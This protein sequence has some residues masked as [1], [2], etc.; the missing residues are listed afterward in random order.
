MESTSLQKLQFLEDYSLI[1]LGFMRGMAELNGIVGASYH[2]NTQTARNSQ[3]R[4][5]LLALL[6]NQSKQTWFGPKRFYPES[7]GIHWT[8]GVPDKGK[9][10]KAKAKGV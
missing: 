6:R 10:G 2:R 1:F 9:R 3:E 4:P 5:L 8:I 7:S